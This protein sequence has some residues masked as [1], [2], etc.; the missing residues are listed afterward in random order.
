MAN[1]NYDLAAYL[2][3]F[4]LFLGF[5]HCNDELSSESSEASSGKAGGGRNLLQDSF[6]ESYRGPLK[7]YSPCNISFDTMDYTVFR[8]GCGELRNPD[9]HVPRKTCCAAFILFVCPVREYISDEHSLCMSDMVMNIKMRCGLES[10]YF[11][12]FCQASV[13]KRIDCEPIDE[14]RR[15]N[16]KSPLYVPPPGAARGDHGTFPDPELLNETAQSLASPPP[17]E[18]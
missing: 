10:T 15:R 6:S 3:C 14:I 13:E 1:Q 2:T 9:D 11:Y 5:A 17:P 4:L 16:G 12:N 7:G 8:K 18:P